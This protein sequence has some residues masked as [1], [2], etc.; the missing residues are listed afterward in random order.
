IFQ[1]DLIDYSN[2]P[3][4]QFRY[5]VGVIDLFSRYAWAKAITA[6]TPQ[7]VLNA[8]I[9]LDIPQRPK[10]LIS[11]N[12]GE[13]L[14]SFSQHLEKEKVNHVFTKS[15]SPQQNGVIERWNGT[16]KQ[17]LERNKMT[18]GNSWADYIKKALKIYN[19]NVHSST[20][21]PPVDVIDTRPTDEV[22]QNVR[23]KQR[24]RNERKGPARRTPVLAV[25][26]HVRKKIIKNKHAKHSTDNFSRDIYAVKKIR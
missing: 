2:K 5:I 1:I 26:D 10:K 13:F 6:K 22:F 19:D 3:A 4:R 25:G 23:N 14:G 15:H 20:G 24:L 18:E 12:G 11:D 9:D 16:F 17:L 21:Y 7:K 8:Y